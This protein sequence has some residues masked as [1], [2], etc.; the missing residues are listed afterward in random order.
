MDSKSLDI[1]A[2]SKDRA[3]NY[4]AHH[5]KNPRTALTTRRE[6]RLLTDALEAAGRPATALDLPCGTGRFWAAFAAAGVRELL[7]ADNSEGMLG[8]AQTAI[9]DAGI[10]VRLFRTSVFEVRLPAS[11]VP[12]IACMRFFHHLSRSDDRLRALGELH[13][14]SSRDVIVSLW[15]DGCLQSLLRSRRRKAPKQTAGYGKRICLER[16]VFETE[17]AISGFDIVSRRRVWPGLS[18]W[19]FYHLRKVHGSSQAG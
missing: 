15:T 4:A 11:S 13:R 17:I 3:A 16:E 5:R 1:D 7:A 12:A 9:A 2:Y 14:V 10:P 8:V 18:M 6:Q 19:T